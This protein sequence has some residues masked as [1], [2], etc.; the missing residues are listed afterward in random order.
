M[1]DEKNTECLLYGTEQ[2]DMLNEKTCLSC[3]IGKLKPEEQQKT[4]DALIR[5]AD[6]AP[7]ETVEQ[8]Y[9]TDE[10]VFCKGPERNKAEGYALFDMNRRD[11]EGDWTFQL[12]KKKYAAKTGFMLLPLQASCCKKCRTRFRVL[13][14]VPTI[15]ALVL[16]F[17]GLF[18]TTNKDVYNS[19]YN[20]APWMPL[21][22]F[23]A[24]VGVSLLLATALRMM[25]SSIYSKHT[26]L[27]LEELEPVKKL[28][29]NDWKLVGK[30]R[31]GAHTPVFSKKLRETGIFTKNEDPAS[32][33]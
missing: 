29:E 25:F 12:G 1:Y 7:K 8:L 13:E 2:C 5:L 16:V 24:F 4:K 14:F 6:A 30:K 11:E 27:D 15:A 21:V 19:L 17:I 20:I 18:V 9:D 23:I 33:E 26:H 22:V 32:E 3:R 28:M 10:C 31:A